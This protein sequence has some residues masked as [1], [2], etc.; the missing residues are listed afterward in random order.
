VGQQHRVVPAI[1]DLVLSR[2]RGALHRQPARAAD[3]RREQFGE[4]RLGRPRLA[5]QQQ[6]PF[7]RQRHDAA[8]HQR[9]LADELALDHLLALARAD[10]PAGDEGDHGSRRQS[11]A[12]RSR[13]VVRLGQRRQLAGVPVLGRIDLTL[14]APTISACGG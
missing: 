9:P 5:D 3:R 12:R 4:H 10:L 11:P 1:A 8:L 14:H 6:R 13:S 2:A 7:P